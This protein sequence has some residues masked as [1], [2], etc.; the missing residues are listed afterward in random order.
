MRVPVILPKRLPGTVF[1]DE[2]PP[3]F[4]VTFVPV[5]PLVPFVES[6]A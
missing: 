1:G 2:H 5:V 6:T 3:R 4:H